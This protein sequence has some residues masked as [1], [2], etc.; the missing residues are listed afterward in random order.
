MSI[1]ISVSLVDAG[2]FRSLVSDLDAICLSDLDDLRDALANG[3]SEVNR[4]LAVDFLERVGRALEDF[5][6]DEDEAIDQA[7]DE[8]LAREV[9]RRRTAV[10]HLGSRIDET[11]LNDVASLVDA[12]G[13]IRKILAG[14]NLDVPLPSCGAAN[15]GWGIWGAWSSKALEPCLPAVDRFERIADVEEFLEVTGHEMGMRE[16]GANTKRRSTAKADRL[17]RRWIADEHE[18]EMWQQIREA[19]RA[20]VSTGGC[21]VVSG[22]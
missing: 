1:E 13:P 11:T 14:S 20:A 8:L 4:A 19:V 5:D 2:E 10:W 18:W 16:P 17:V 3:S 7:T 21:L 15:D 9:G 12:L 22:S 6:E